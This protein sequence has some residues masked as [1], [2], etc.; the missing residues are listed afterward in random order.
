[1][2]FQP[3]PNCL[4][5]ILRFTSAG[6]FWGVNSLNFVA[7]NPPVADDLP[8]IGAA[9]VDWWTESIAGL[10]SNAVLL[11]TISIR[12]LSSPSDVYWSDNLTGAAGLA[13]TPAMP[14]N[15]TIAL[16][17]E[18][19]LTGKSRRGRVFHVGLGEAMVASKYLVADY[20]D[21]MPDQYQLLIDA[22][23]GY[24][25]QWAVL[26]RTQNKVRLAEAIPY[27]V[28]RCTLVDRKID[29]M[30]DRQVAD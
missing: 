26:S 13:N 20:A 2:A 14:P 10:V 5:V 22:V 25:L 12:G 7:L 3:A 19:G 28:T 29:T 6:T 30:R 17:L 21:P 9:I 27:P 16:K 23:A 24:D 15:V 18:T 1:M 4:N 8:G 11:D